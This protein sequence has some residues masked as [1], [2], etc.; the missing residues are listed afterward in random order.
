[1]P[2]SSSP[3]EPIVLSS[4]G[5]QEPLAALCQQLIAERGQVL[6]CITGKTGAGKSTLGR[7]VRKRGLPGIPPRD[8]AVIDDGVLAVKFLGLFNRRIKHRSLERDNLDPF[9]PFVRNKKLL[10]Y[11]NGRPHLR[12]E[13]CDVVL[14]LRIADELRQQRLIRRDTDGAERFQRSLGISDDLTIAADHC[15]DLCLADDAQST[16]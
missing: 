7:H 16:V 13:R 10:V 6:L 8:I 5:W 14:R 15:F 2:D 9:R 12:L 4:Q 3:P 11:V 1:M